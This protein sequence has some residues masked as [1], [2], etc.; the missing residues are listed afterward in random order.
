[1]KGTRLILDGRDITGTLGPGGAFSIARW[2]GEASMMLRSTV[3]LVPF[4]DV[5][6]GSLHSVDLLVPVKPPRFLG[7]LYQLLGRTHRV[8]PLGI[9]KIVRV[10]YASG[11]VD[12]I[13]LSTWTARY[14]VIEP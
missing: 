8:L 6:V 5:S 10:S 14:A 2:P 3:G 13:D 12:F 11:T 9:W 1:M 7:W 4:G